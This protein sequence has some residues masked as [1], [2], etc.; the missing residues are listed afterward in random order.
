[1]LLLS[2]SL[3]QSQELFRKA[4]D[5]YR[6]F[7][8]TAPTDSESALRMELDNGSRIVSL[9]GS[10]MISITHSSPCRLGWPSHRPL[11]SLPWLVVRGLALSRVVAALSG[12]GQRVRPDQSGVL[13][14]EQRTMGQW[15]FAQ[16]YGCEFV[17]AQTQAF[18]RDDVERA[19]SEAVDEWAL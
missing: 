11:H 1:V 16:E 10:R 19:F 4:L 8:H 15:W 18:S 13:E 7:A 14:E 17:A 9:P 3:R 2:P 5:V 6:P 12:A